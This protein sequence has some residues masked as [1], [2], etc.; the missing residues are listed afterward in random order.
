MSISNTKTH[1]GVISIVLHWIMACLII[2]LFVLG[3]YMVTLDYYDS[4]YHSAPWW[5]KSFA[6][7]VFILLLIRLSWRWFHRLPE[8]LAGYKHW[9]II[10]AKK[11]HIAFYIVIFVTCISG[12]FIS[13]A[14]GA[15]I[16]FFNWFDIPALMTLSEIQA[17]I[18]AKSHELMTELLASLLLV[19]VIAALKHHF[20]NKDITLIRMLKTNTKKE[21]LK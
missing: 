4:W 8:P 10:I 17:E 2:G 15:S 5:H 21:N 11:V 9:E 12:Y 13:S 20:I 7:I 19:H 18:A 1:Y 6:L 14:T 16:E 3:Q